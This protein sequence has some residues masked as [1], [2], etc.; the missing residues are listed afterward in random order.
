M[1]TA[2]AAPASHSTELSI[3]TESEKRQMSALSRIVSAY[4]TYLANPQLGEFERALV[5]CKAIEAIEQ[6]LPPEILQQFVRLMDSPYGFKTDRNSNNTDGTK[7]SAYPLEVVRSCIIQAWLAGATIQGNQF[8][9]IAGNSYLTKV[10]YRKAI[11]ATKGV[12]DLRLTIGTPQRYGD[13]SAVCEAKAEWSYFGKPQVLKFLKTEELDARI[14]VNTF[15][16]NGPDA[17]RGRVESKLYQRVF[18][19][20]TGL[21]H[22]AD[23]AVETDT[24]A[25]SISQEPTRAIQAPREN[26]DEKAAKVTAQ[27]LD[28]DVALEIIE[29]LEHDLVS[30]T[31]IVAIRKLVHD[32]ECLVKSAEWSQSLKEAT[33]NSIQI[34]AQDRVEQIRA[35]RAEANNYS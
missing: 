18:S 33:I 34:A 13:S 24:I 27:L 15:H 12:A 11:L 1:T 22:E 2:V 14:V 19:V 30:Q 10:F 6:L 17:I 23:E 35:S 29:A 16:S 31:S 7:K 5:Q 20:L 26:T 25:G 4:R 21:N 32:R 28:G 8:N 3:L 9:I